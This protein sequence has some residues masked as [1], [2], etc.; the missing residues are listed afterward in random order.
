MY[1]I[2]TSTISH[3][4]IENSCLHDD[5]DNAPKLCIPS[6]GQRGENIITMCL[7]AI[8]QQG[9]GIDKHYHADVKLKSISIEECQQI[10]ATEG[11][12]NLK[13]DTELCR[14]INQAIN[15]A[16]V[17]SAVLLIKKQDKNDPEPTTLQLNSLIQYIVQNAYK[18]G[19]SPVRVLISK[20]LNDYLS[21][22]TSAGVSNY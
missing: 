17:I 6:V 15:E 7:G 3:S 8:H 1:K 12:P 20:G 16:V 19:N 14:M 21:K 4:Q 5:E 11:Y 13:V 2:Q 10:L 18:E 9:R 22:E